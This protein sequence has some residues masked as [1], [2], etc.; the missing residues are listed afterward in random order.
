MGDFLKMKIVVK[1]V[2]CISFLFFIGLVVMFIL[3]ECVEDI[4]DIEI[5]DYIFIDGCGFILFNFV[6]ELVRCD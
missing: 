1:K 2:K 4:F 5:V 3:F 6:W